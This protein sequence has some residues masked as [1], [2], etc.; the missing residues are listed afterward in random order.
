I[1]GRLQWIMDAYTAS[2]R[3]PYSQPLNRS[4][5]IDSLLNTAALR[6]LTR[7][8]NNYLRD[9]AK[10]TIDAYDGTLNFYVLD[11]TDPIL[12][13]YRKIFPDLFQTAS[14]V[15][16]PVRAHFR[17]PHDLFTLQAQ[18][19][20]TYH[21]GNAEV[22]Y[23]REDLWQFPTQKYEQDEVRMD[24][25]YTIMRLPEATSEEFIK[26][27]PFTPNNRDNMV[28][29]MAGRSDA[30]NYGKLLLY[31]FPKQQLVYGP[32]QIEARIDQTPEISE[33]I[34]LLGQR[35]SRVIRGDLLVLPIEESLLYVEP[36]YLQAEQGEL[37][38]LKR[39]IVAYGNEVVMGETLEESLT[40]IFGDRTTPAA[41]PAM[42]SSEVDVSE[43]VALPGDLASQVQAALDAY[44]AGRQA[45]QQGDWEAYGQAQKTLEEILNQLNQDL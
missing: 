18:I 16:E 43:P 45:L 19:Y 21:M 41:A 40:A 39:V 37:P 8:G 30:D 10:V 28:S 1:D 9:A 27:L 31:E 32:S 34:T 2:D 42:P 11:E 38:E 5:G 24:P 13:T 20:R 14:E 3:Y 26:I 33:L 15:P 22:F 23:N 7:Q 44:E 36:V 35:G 6:N 12:S 29:W 4:S 25:Y 17:Y